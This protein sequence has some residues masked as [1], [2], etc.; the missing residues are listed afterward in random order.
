MDRTNYDIII[1]GAGPAGLMAALQCCGAHKKTC[2]L[3]RMPA[4]AMKL[5]ITGKGRC[6][7][8]NS[9]DRKQAM[10]HF[11]A[12]GRFLKYAF[13]KFY[14]IDLL[15]FFNRLGI[16][17]V[18]ERGGRYFPEHKDAGKVAAALLNEINRENIE[19][20]TGT[21]VTDIRYIT[22]KGFQ[23]SLS[24]KGIT[25]NGQ[26]NLNVLQADKVLLGTGGKSYPGTGS[27]GSGFRLAAK[28]GHTITPLYPSLVPLS[29]ET[30]IEQ[31]LDGLVLKNV[32]VSAW[33]NDEKIGEDF[34]EMAFCQR[35]IEG[36]VVLAQSGKIVRQLERQLPVY[37]SIDLKPALDHHK[38]E[39]RLLRELNRHDK[40][41]LKTLLKRLLPKKMIPVFLR[42]LNIAAEKPLNRITSKER[43]SLRLLLKHFSIRITGHSSFK[44]ALVTSGGVCLDE[45]NPRTMESRR[46]KN[47][48]FAGEILDLDADTGGFNLQA[49]F[50]TG[51]LAG[52]SL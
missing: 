35:G 21:A 27:N 41:N 45:I 19:L 49:A 14:N 23:V 1:I 22:G 39:A 44:N 50:S 33:C 37:I 29:S 18:L 30:K 11:G 46:V 43:K 9:A 2:V 25:D 47:L 4:V 31:E 26:S 28:L 16:H 51:W 52:R 32:A 48:F 17:F 38:L 36:P 40:Q 20:I 10:N 15:S 42:R 6:N 7:L 13:G 24:G 34:G 12:N 5:K 8:T 3:E